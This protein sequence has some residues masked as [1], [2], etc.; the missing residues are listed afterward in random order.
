MRPVKRLQLLH[1]ILS[2]ARLTQVVDIGANPIN[3]RPPYAL[4]RRAG[5]CHVTG[6][7]PDPQAFAALADQHQANVT[8]LPQAVGCGGDATLYL[9]P[10]SGLTST[11]PL[12]DWVGDYLGRYWDRGRAGVVAKPITT[13]RLDDVAT[14]TAIDFLKIDIQGGELA[15]FRNA[16]DKLAETAMIQTEAALLPYYKGQDDLGVQIAELRALGFHPYRLA[17]VNRHRLAYN[18]DLGRGIATSRSQV[19]DLD[20]VFL[21]DPIAMGQPDETL[22]HLTLL[23]DAVLGASDLVLR[24]L[25]ELV[26]R[27]LATPAALRPYLDALQTPV[28]AAQAGAAPQD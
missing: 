16:A 25:T 13:V 2:P 20:V 21:R 23:A 17:E 28:D 15:V 26:R 7:E 27:G 9:S 4:L 10:H 8:I 19:L 22:K 14:V 3:G 1:G 18:T 6:F 24:C 11:L 12:A 5:L